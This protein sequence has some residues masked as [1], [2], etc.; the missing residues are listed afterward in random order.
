M[1][2]PLGWDYF[3]CVVVVSNSNRSL[4]VLLQASARSEAH[5]AEELCGEL[6]VQAKYTQ[7]YEDQVEYH[8]A[9]SQYI[10]LDRTINLQFIFNV[11]YRLLYWFTVPLLPREEHQQAEYSEEGE[12]STRLI[13]DSPANCLVPARHVH[14]SSMSL[15][16][17]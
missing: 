9:C 11:R 7:D 4:I 13:H 5:P 15:C 2:L 10:A 6:R 16:I 1:F 8:G 12:I 3:V 14:D 17:H